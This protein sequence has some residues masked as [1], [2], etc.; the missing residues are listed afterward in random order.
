MFT[1]QA[2]PRSTSLKAKQLRKQGLIP[3]G[4]YG[5]D[6][7]KSLQIKQS[8]VTRLIKSKTTGGNVLL[9]VEGEKINAIIREIGR[10]PV[11]GKVEH[12]SFQEVNRNELVTNTAQIVLINRDKIPEYIQQVLFEIPYKAIVSK[13]IETI[14]ID[15]DGMKAGT[16][17]KVMDLEIAKNDDIELLIDPDSLVVSIIE[18]KS[19][20]K[21][22]T[23]ETDEI[24]E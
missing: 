5:G 18:R 2:E 12:I 16:S 20:I 1:L 10:G 15:L 23:D 13:L 14:E 19:G 6:I 17:I 11:S 24:D 8:E 3:V 9:D 7:N 22:E 21:T 4:L